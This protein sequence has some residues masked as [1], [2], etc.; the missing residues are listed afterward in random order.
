MFEGNISITGKKS[1]SSI[2]LEAMID[3]YSLVN[4][5]TPFR[6]RVLVLRM[7]AVSIG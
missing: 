3:E 6:T 7:I 2:V 5:S 4:L 1:G